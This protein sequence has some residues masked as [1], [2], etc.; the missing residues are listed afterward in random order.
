MNRYFLYTI[1]VISFL[2]L[3][4]FGFFLVTF[5]KNLQAVEEAEKQFT[6]K[7]ARYIE[8]YF[9]KESYTLELSLDPDRPTLTPSELRNKWL[10]EFSL[11]AGISEASVVDS[12]GLVFSTTSLE[13]PTGSWILS[14]KR[15]SAFVERCLF[16]TPHLWS[17]YDEGDQVRSLLSYHRIT[18]DD[19]PHVLILISNRNF[20][21]QT[22]RFRTNITNTSI[23]FGVVLIL[24]LASLRYLHKRSVQAEQEMLKSSELAFLGRTSAELAHDLKNP[25]AIIK[26]TSEAL[27]RDPKP[28]K[29]VQLL[30]FISEEV[31]KMSTLITRILNFD[32]EAPVLIEKQ[33]LYTLL[34]RTVAPLR[35]KHPTLKIELAVEKSFS[36]L[37]DPLL[38]TQISENVIHN[39]VKAVSASGRICIE[40]RQ[41][42]GRVQILFYDT[43]AGVPRAIREK[44]FDP[45]VSG[46]P[47]GTGLGLAIVQNCC[48]RLGGEV[49]LLEQCKKEGYTT[50]F[51]V[52]LPLDME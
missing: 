25:L 36:F 46:A 50:C 12:L 3:G 49:R 37:T 26:S 1:S 45:F 15:D 31:S 5:S 38:F 11:A 52:I 28:E 29:R 14:S 6:L 43:G 35:E 42:R 32:K 9:Q 34:M 7:T 30:D 13:Y 16:T 22:E 19:Q 41:E 10:Q 23:A 27:M 2:L 18:I 17:D 21:A 33:E 24:L 44:L 48:E 4:L 39:A 20:I 47:N 40:S 8:H 51:E